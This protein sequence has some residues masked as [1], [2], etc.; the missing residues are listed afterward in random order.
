MM[1]VRD[2]L[3]ATLRCRGVED[4]EKA[5]K[6]WSDEKR[7]EVATILSELRGK[8]FFPDRINEHGEI[9]WGVML[10]S[11]VQMMMERP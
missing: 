11:K 3:K 10:K 4:F 9:V 2:W 7:S 6:S 5:V 1:L 8:G